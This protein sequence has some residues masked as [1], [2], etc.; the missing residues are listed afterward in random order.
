MLRDHGTKIRH[1]DP[2]LISLHSEGVLT[3]PVYI[4]AREALSPET[5]FFIR[6]IKTQLAID[7]EEIINMDFPGFHAR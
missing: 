7:E 3:T 4:K 5:F 1:T 2:E 6:G